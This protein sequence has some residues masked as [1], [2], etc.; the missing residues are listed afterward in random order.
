MTRLAAI[1]AGI[2]VNTW[3]RTIT[4]TVT[5]FLTVVA[6]EV[7]LTLWFDLVLSAALGNV[8][9]LYAMLV[10][11]ACQSSGKRDNCT[12]AITA[13]RRK[14]IHGFAGVSKALH[15]LLHTGWPSF[16]KLRT[17]RLG[18]IVKADDELA[19]LLALEVHIGD[20][21]WDLFL[22]QGMSN[23]NTWTL[24]SLTRAMR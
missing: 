21:E 7:R 18:G 15:V 13:Q 17:L 10:L 3:L 12:I 20:G 22:L 23:W 8:A 9:K 4:K 5:L 11:M 24:S 16:R 14:V 19:I 1:L 6:L 2:P